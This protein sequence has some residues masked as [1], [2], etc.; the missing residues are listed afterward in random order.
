[1]HE[2]G[3]AI[4]KAIEKGQIYASRYESYVRMRLSQE[5]EIG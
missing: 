1:V 4:L 3:C 5:D 2:P